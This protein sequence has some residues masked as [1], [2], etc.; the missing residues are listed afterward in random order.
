MTASAAIA[1]FVMAAG[2]GVLAIRAAIFAA[3]GSEASAR[4]M[5]TAWRLIGGHEKSPADATGKV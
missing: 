2:D 1:G 5:R 4:D 3:V